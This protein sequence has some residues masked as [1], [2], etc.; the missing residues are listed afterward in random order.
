MLRMPEEQALGLGHHG[1]GGPGQHG[2]GRQA[3]QVDEGE[4]L[5]PGND[6]GALGLVPPGHFGLEQGGENGRLGGLAQQGLLVAGAQR[7]NLGQGEKG[8][9]RIPPLL[10]D[11]GVGDKNQAAGVPPRRQRRQDG[12][13]VAF[14]RQAIQRIARK[15]DNGG[16]FVNEWIAHENG[17]GCSDILSCARLC[18]PAIPRCAVVARAPVSP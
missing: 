4:I 2:P 1:D 14:L 16:K 8:V 17:S 9:E 7:R 5:T 6:E 10:Q 13:I 12:R 18:E 11:R 15:A 3:A